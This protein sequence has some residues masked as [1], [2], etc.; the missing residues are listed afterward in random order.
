MMTKRKEGRERK[1]ER[2][3]DRQTDRQRERQ[4]DRQREVTNL[5]LEFGLADFLAVVPKH[6]KQ[7]CQRE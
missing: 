4:T 5:H 2:E 6:T 7:H 3:R 1:R